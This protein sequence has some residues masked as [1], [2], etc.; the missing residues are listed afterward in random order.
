VMPNISESLTRQR[1]QILSDSSEEMLS[2]HTSLLEIAI[3]SLYNRMVNRLNLDAEQFRS[4]GAV[5]AVGAFGRGLLGPHQAIPLL[6]LRSESSPWQEGWVEEITSPLREADWTVDVQE[7]ST[8]V[9]LERARDDFSFFL[10][11]LETH[12]ISGNRQLAEQLVERERQGRERNRLTLNLRKAGFPAIK[13][14]EEF[15]FR[16]QTT[17]T[18]RQINQLLDFRLLD[19]RANRVFI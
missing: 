14:L 10:S 4:S 19:E 11:L 1:E 18:K 9:L 2:R 3:I 13:R 8:G 12:Y 7:G 5:L 6:F 15:D 17:I 16:H